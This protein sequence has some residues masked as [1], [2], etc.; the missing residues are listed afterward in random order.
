MKNNEREE[1]EEA[2]AMGGVEGR[3]R[4]WQRAEGKMGERMHNFLI[5]GPRENL[6]TLPWVEEHVWSY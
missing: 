5:R 4:R 1:A 3:S 2:E 6:C